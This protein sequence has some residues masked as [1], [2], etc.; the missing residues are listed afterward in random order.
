MDDFL[1]D[2]MAEV[3]AMCPGSASL[4]ELEFSH[5][6]RELDRLDMR[7]CG[8][9]VAAASALVVLAQVLLAWWLQ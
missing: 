4:C 5:R 8:L 6:V 7:A 3:D 2:A 9:R 1:I